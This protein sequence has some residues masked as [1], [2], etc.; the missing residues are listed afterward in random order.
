M[1]FPKTKNELI[2]SIVRGGVGVMPTDTVYGIVA[3]AMD[4][5]AVEHI[6]ELKKR[7]SN[8]PFVIL[9]S[10]LSDLKKFGI[11]LSK[12]A[13]CILPK[14]WPNKVSV[15]LPCQQ[16]RFYYLHRGHKTLAF[17]MPDDKKLLDLLHLTGPLATSS[18]NLSGQPTARNIEQAKQYFGRQIDFYANGGELANEP[19]TLIEIKGKKILI[20]RQGGV[21][22]ESIVR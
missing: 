6:Y 12:T 1:P 7:D 9:I 20:K 5:Q 8:K 19:S 11:K 21:R 14:I 4:T 10:K 17:R 18:A 22:I 13:Q 15:I 16:K 2:R 3:S